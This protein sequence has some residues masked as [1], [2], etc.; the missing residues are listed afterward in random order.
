MTVWSMR[1]YV[2]DV[3]FYVFDDEL[4]DFM[5]YVFLYVLI[6]VRFGNNSDLLLIDR[7]STIN[8]VIV[9]IQLLL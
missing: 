1:F 3:C 5:N 7:L 8:E 9:S 4:C 6:T 2:F